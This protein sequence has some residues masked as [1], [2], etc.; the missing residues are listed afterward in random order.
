MKNRTYHSGIKRMP[1]KVLFGCK[2]RMG[3]RM[4]SL[5]Q[6]T[7]KYVQSKEVLE[8]IT[9]SIKTTEH[10]AEA[11]PIGDKKYPHP[12]SSMAEKIIYYVCSK[13]ITSVHTHWTVVKV[14]IPFL[15]I[16]LH[17][18][19]VTKMKPLVNFCA[20]LFQNRECCLSKRGINVYLR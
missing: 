9:D 13:E 8:K 16:L 10:G 1:Y 19:K 5:S 17:M 2:K 14:F 15:D 11:S 20:L 12:K 3:L 4:S 18:V 7:L 6:H